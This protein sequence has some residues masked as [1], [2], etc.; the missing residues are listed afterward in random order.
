MKKEI[1]KKE[2]LENELNNLLHG[3]Q[4]LPQYKE[5]LKQ[6][7]KVDAAMKSIR[8]NYLVEVQVEINAI[9]SK[10]K[11]LEIKKRA[12]NTLAHDP[13][14]HGEK[15][16]SFWDQLHFGSEEYR[17]KKLIWI[18]AKKEICLIK[19]PSY[20]SGGYYHGV[21]WQLIAVDPIKFLWTAN[22]KWTWIKK[23]AIETNVG[24]KI[25]L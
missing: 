10:L 24:I 20:I 9:K 17:R 15:F 18:D 1:V 13:A 23:T 4:E 25:D 21:K 7:L 22:G 5:T 19:I 11:E 3:F 12:K 6:M 8:Y 14:L 2:D 16:L